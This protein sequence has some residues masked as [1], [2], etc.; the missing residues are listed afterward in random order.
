MHSGLAAGAAADLPS[1]LAA[2]KN[3]GAVASSRSRLARPTI[4]FH[5]DSDATVHP[6]NGEHVLSASIGLAGGKPELESG[7]TAD[8][9][10]YTR[11]IHR[12]A[13]GQVLAEHWLVHG[14]DHAW[15]GGSR[16]GSYTDPAG[17]DATGQMVRFFLQHPKD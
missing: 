14:A 5:G 17:P 6:G 12:T 3:G 2:M 16:Q 7:Q 11:Q 9:R 8:G 13:E 10:G 4:V 15:S 1:A